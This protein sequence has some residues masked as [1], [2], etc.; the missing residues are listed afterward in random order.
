MAQAE[1][2]GGVRNGE[3]KHRRCSCS[4]RSNRK[5][6]HGKARGVYRTA[7]GEQLH[8]D[9]TSSQLPDDLHLAAGYV[10]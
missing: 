9:P 8:A 5:K 3:G 4:S 2:D 6:G 7:P 10:R 1:S